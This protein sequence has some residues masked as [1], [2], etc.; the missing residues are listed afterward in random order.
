[1]FHFLRRFILLTASFL[2]LLP[3][4]CRASSFDGG[5]DV[6]VFSDA[7]AHSFLLMDGKTGDVLALRNADEKLPMASTTKIMTCLVALE[8]AAVSDDVVVHKD[9]VGIEGSS[10]YLVKDEKLKLEELLYALMLESANDAACAIAFHISGSIPAFSDLMNETARRI[11][12]D[13]TN[14]VNPHGLSVDGHYSTARDLCKLMRYAMQNEAFREI[15]GTETI[16][17]SAPDGK[18]RFLSNHNKLLRL[19][20]ECTGGKTGFTKKAGRCLV[21]SAKRGE[22][23]LICA[24]LGDPDDWRDHR[25]LFDYGFSLYSQRQVA[26]VKQFRFEIPVVGGEEAAVFVSNRESFEYL[27][28]NEEKIDYHIELPRFVYAPEKEGKA[29]GEVIFKNGELEIFRMPLTLETDVLKREEKLSF[30]EKIM[31][32]IRLW[33]D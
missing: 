28:R 6:P 23:E 15:T 17:I 33:F 16:S 8:V 3:I 21:T 14:F 4:T 7:S 32:K 30:W 20:E 9:A 19:Y 12:L 25:V 13:R 5:L 29:V 1:M 11:G 2:I 22:K 26:D 24:T 27:L 10:V 18:T 31:Q